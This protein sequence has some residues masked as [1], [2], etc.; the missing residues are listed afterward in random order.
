MFKFEPQSS[1]FNKQQYSLH[2]TV[3]YTTDPNCLHHYYYHL[4]DVKKHDYAYTS[5]VVDHILSIDCVPE[6]IRFKSDNCV[7]Q[8]KSK[9]VFNYWQ[10]LSISQNRKVILYY[11]VA[12]HGKGL[13]DAMSSF[14]VKAPLRR[15]VITHDFTYNCASD[16]HSYL[17]KLFE[18]DEQKH[19]FFLE[20][21]TITEKICTQ[22][23]KVKDCQALHMICF[24]PNGSYCTK[25]NICSCQNCL[26]GE[27]LD[28]VNETE[29]MLHQ[30]AMTNTIVRVV[31]VML[32]TT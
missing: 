11:G 4:S 21:T 29:N 10:S 14:G 15:A 19:H 32:A 6:I 8:Y 27:F 3:K 25:D 26:L 9:N 30:G 13:V 31:T 20:D 18:N 28:S 16:I 1:H 22:V 5:A 12:G 23:L 2:C 17:Q 24:K 7:T